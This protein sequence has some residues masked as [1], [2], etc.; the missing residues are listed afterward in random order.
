MGKW[1]HRE[2]TCLPYPRWLSKHMRVWFIQA[3]ELSR[4]GI[5]LP[6]PVGFP[7]PLILVCTWIQLLQSCPT[8]RDAM[9]YGSPGSLSMGFSRQEYWSELPCPP[10]G[11]LPNPGIKLSS[12]ASHTLDSLPLVL[13]GKPHKIAWLIVMERC[14]LFFGYM[15][16]HVT[17]QFIQDD[18]I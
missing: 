17:K 5:L 16:T 11:D 4:D 14:L 10:P 7:K 13:P 2:N 12:P 9:D 6:H 8:L 1:R 3:V 15:N 18:A